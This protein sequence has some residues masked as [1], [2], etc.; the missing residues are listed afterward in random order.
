MG[1]LDW[2]IQTQKI[3]LD[4]EREPKAALS[5]GYLHFQSMNA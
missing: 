2:A 3:S 1:K 4:D 5:I